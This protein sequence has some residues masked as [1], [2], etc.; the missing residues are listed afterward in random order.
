MCRARAHDIFMKSGCYLVGPELQQ[1]GVAQALVHAVHSLDGVA[2]GDSFPN[3]F[4]TKIPRFQFV[5]ANEAPA[6]AIGHS[7]CPKI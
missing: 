6:P 5:S 2:A 1:I 3:I 4:T 7:L